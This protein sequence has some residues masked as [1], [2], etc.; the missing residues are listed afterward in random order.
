MASDIEHIV[1]SAVLTGVA[2]INPKISTSEREGVTSLHQAFRS[3]FF[4]VNEEKRSVGMML[5]E[6]QQIIQKTMKKKKLS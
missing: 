6:V 1:R 3:D 2:A 5:A 4:G